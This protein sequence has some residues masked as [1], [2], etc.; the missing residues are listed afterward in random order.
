MEG[1]D[2][3]RRRSPC[4]RRRSGAAGGKL[5]VISGAG[6]GT[7]SSFLGDWASAAGGRVVR[8]QPFDLEPVRAANAARLRSRRD[9]GA[10]TSAPR[11]TSSPSALTSSRP[12]ARPPRTS[13]ATPSRHGF[14]RGSEPAKHVYFAPRASLTGLNADEWHAVVPGSRDVACPRDGR[15]T[16]AGAAV[17][18][19]PG[20]PS[21]SVE[22][23]GQG[24]GPGGRDDHAAREGIRGGQPEPRGGGRHRQPDRRR[25]RALRCG[26]TCS[27]TP[28]AT[29]G[30]RC[31]SAP[32]STTATA[33]VRSRRCR[34]RMGAGEVQ[35]LLV[36]EANP[37]YTAPRAAEVRRGA[38][39]GAVQG[40]DRRCSSTRR[41]RRATCCCPSH[42]ALERWDDLKPAP[43]VWGL[44]QPVLTPVFNTHGDRATC[45]SRPRRRPAARWRSSRPASWEDHAQ[46][47]L[48]G[49]LPRRRRRCGGRRWRRAA[50]TQECAGGAG[51]G[52]PARRS[53]PRAPA[54]EG[55][56]EFTLLA[57]RVVA[58]LRWAR[59]QPPLAGRESRSRHQDHLAVVGGAEPRG[60][61]ANQRARRRDPEAHLAARFAR[62]GGLHLSRPPRPTWSRCRSGSGTPSWASY[63]KGRGVNYLDLLG[64]V[65]GLV[66]SRTCRSR[67]RWS[68][69]S[70]YQKVAKTEGTTRQLGR[71]I[72]EAMPLAYA[73]KGHDAGAVG[74]GG[75]SPGA[76]DQHRRASSRR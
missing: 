19:S 15:R 62:G 21:V 74:Q 69:P 64:P 4:W 68:A 26:R 12:S 5:A 41:R 50:C 11:S 56:G 10:T 33:T 31:A 72:A 16:R 6:R 14:T 23:C 27:T 73:A 28:P 66:R 55:T 9:P 20:M 29:S 60:G 75:G 37:V 49:A 18:A 2:L 8:Y 3:G 63:A 24:H 36:H 44:M 39:Q 57:V 13:W 7:F 30:R 35:V 32:T 51:E 42:H 17:A 61:A 43:G 65:S 58:L 22:R 45:C 47:R 52:R 38:G 71:G 40:L 54:F 34:G 67:C 59:G 1:R 25:H 76:R 70:A 48:A 46:V 53:A